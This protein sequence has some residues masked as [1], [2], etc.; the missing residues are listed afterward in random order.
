MLVSRVHPLT[1][2]ARTFDLNVTPDQLSR[3]EN[4]ELVQAAFPDLTADE[5]EFIMT[6]LT[7]EEFNE[8]FSEEE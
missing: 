1:G 6:G 4:G 3:W 5:R 7:G 2:R 8:L